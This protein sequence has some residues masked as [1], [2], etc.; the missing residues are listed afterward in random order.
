MNRRLGS[1]KVALACEWV[2]PLIGIGCDECARENVT[3]LH[4][5]VV[6]S[7]TCRECLAATARR[8]G[9]HTAAAWLENHPD[10]P[11]EPE[12]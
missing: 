6:G 10:M 4:D 3:L 5:P 2:T 11:G 12:Q 8:L 9:A 7:Y 1:R